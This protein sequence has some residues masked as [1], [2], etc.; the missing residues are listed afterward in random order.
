L[1]FSITGGDIDVQV[2]KALLGKV[3]KKEI[4]LFDIL[5]KNCRKEHG[6]SG[7]KKIGY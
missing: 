6:F 7:R 2:R 4:R 3:L 5:E 1:L